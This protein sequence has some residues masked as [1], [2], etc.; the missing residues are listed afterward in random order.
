MQRFLR[1]HQ[2]LGKKAVD[3]LAYKKV[4]V[5]GLGAVGS[6]AVEALARSGVGFLTLVDCDKVQKTNINRQ[7]YALESNFDCLKTKVA[8]KR[9][10]EINPSCQV[11]TF[12]LFAHKENFESIFFDSNQ[13][14][15]LVIDAIDSLSPKAFLLAYC[16]HNNIPV[17]SS[18]GAAGKINPFDIKVGDILETKNCSLA[19]RIR[20]KLLNLGVQKGIACVY[21]EEIPKKSSLNQHLAQTEITQQGRPRTSL[22]SLCTLTGI[23]GLLLAHE[24]L[25]KLGAFKEF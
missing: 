14:P 24:G 18:M 1:V 4:V 25:K 20:K 3:D 21:S 23:F 13:K 7:L 6:F 8:S 15:H 2:L 5:V 19:K 9:V 12:N 11:K 16:Y 10:L 22:G 17:L